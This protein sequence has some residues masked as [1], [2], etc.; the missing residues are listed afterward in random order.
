M[1]IDSV[2]IREV[3]LR[4]KESLEISRGPI[5]GRKIVLFEVESGEKVGSSERPAPAPITGGSLQVAV[6][7]LRY[8]P[9]ATGEAA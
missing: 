6:C 9:L 4:L 1:R 5:L 3:H 7:H 2:A 8:I